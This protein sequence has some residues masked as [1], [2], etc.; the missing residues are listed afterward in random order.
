MPKIN[1]CKLVTDIIYKGCDS[2]WSI[3]NIA[4]KTLNMKDKDFMN[5]KK[6]KNILGDIKPWQEIKLHQ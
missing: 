2:W 6:I 4:A 5:K 1:F 3:N